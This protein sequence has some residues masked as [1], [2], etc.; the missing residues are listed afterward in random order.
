MWWEIT[1]TPSQQKILEGPKTIDSLKAA[2]FVG[3]QSYIDD[4]IKDWFQHNR[5]TKAQ[6]PLCV[7][8]SI[9]CNASL[10][11]R[12]KKAARQAVISNEVEWLQKHCIVPVDVW[13]V[14]DFLTVSEAVFDVLWCVS[15]SKKSLCEFIVQSRRMPFLKSFVR[16]YG[17]S[18]CLRDVMQTRWLPAVEFCLLEGANIE[19]EDVV[20]YCVRFPEI[21]RAVTLY[22]PPA[23]QEAYDEF[24]LQCLLNRVEDVP[25]VEE[26]FWINGFRAQF[27]PLCLL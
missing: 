14:V 12:Y 13:S 16:E 10:Q 3:Q 26:W 27:P 17:P 22:N 1:T 25:L 4:W 21:F 5:Y 19:T 15:P 11:C 8:E 18:V 20:Q 7:S 23:I 9:I 24:R 6:L 2:D